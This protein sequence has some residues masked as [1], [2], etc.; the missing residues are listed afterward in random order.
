[1]GVVRDTNKSCGDP[2]LQEVQLGEEART[3]SPGLQWGET[4]C[5]TLCSYL[6]EEGASRVGFFQEERFPGEVESWDSQGPLLLTSVVFLE[7]CHIWQFFK[8]LIFDLFEMGLDHTLPSPWDADQWEE[9][10]ALPCYHWQGAAPAQH[11]PISRGPEA[12]S[13]G[14]LADSLPHL[15]ELPQDNM[16]KHFKQLTLNAPPNIRK[17]LQR[18]LMVSPRAC[19]LYKCKTPINTFPDL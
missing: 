8:F 3:Q 5:W 4:A 11:Q 16:Q 6:L 18:K 14:L 10:L 9:T 12:P 7:Y 17:Q 19:Y 1:M 2:F 13:E 15:F